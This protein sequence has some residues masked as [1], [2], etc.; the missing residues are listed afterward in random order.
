METWK[1]LQ[2]RK[3]PDENFEVKVLCNTGEETQ[4]PINTTKEYG[5]LRVATYVREN[6]I[7]NTPKCMCSIHLINKSNK[8][9]SMSNIF[10]A[11]TK[12]NATNYK[13][14]LF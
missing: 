8:F 12:W 1:D 14:L 5:S 3:L 11:K 6:G 9:I 2:N 10:S 4:D 13:Y 7:L